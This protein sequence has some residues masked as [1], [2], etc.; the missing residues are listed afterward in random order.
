MILR[1]Y[2]LRNE[3]ADPQRRYAAAPADLF[4][5]MREMRSR[6]EK[7]VGI[8]HS[9]PQGPSHPSGTDI[10]LAFYPDAVHLI[11]TPAGSEAELASIAAF[12]IDG[13][14]FQRAEYKIVESI[15]LA[16]EGMAHGA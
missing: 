12:M 4:E 16:E 3:A 6:R 7:L 2:A 8:Y 5:A 14:N 1:P 11:I 10:D 9:H 13:G 15:D